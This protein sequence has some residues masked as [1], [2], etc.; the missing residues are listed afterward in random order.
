MQWARDGH[1]LCYIGIEFAIDGDVY[2]DF[3]LTFIKDKKRQEFVTRILTISLK[4]FKL[5]P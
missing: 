3:A 5:F 1:L 4:T 2:V